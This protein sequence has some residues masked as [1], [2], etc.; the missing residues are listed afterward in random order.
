MACY[1]I[2]DAPSQTYRKC[3]FPI[4]SYIAL[5]ANI[6]NFSFLSVNKFKTPLNTAKLKINFYQQMHFL[7]NI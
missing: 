4:V 7:W 2:S 1:V 5:P 6:F 3:I